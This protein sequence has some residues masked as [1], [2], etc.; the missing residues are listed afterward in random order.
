MADK[1]QWRPET[2]AVRGGYAGDQTTNAISVPIYQTVGF[3]FQGTGHAARLFNLEQ[4]GNIYTRIM[5]PTTDVLE[6]RVALLEGGIAA[7]AFSSGMAAI[8]GAILNLARAGDEIVAST[9]LYGGTWTLFTSTLQDFGISVRLLAEED[10]AQADAL[11]NERTKGVFVE[12]IGNP[13]LDIT[14][15][16]AWADLAH[17]HGVPLI[18]DNTFA[19]PYL[20]R[21][22][23]HG[24]DIVVHSLTKWIGG[25]GNALGG[26]VVDSGRFNYDSAR[27]P[28]YTKPDPSYHGLV[29]STL[30]EAAYITR[31]RVK[32]LRDTG[33]AISP[34]N[35]YYVLQGLETL[36]IRM[37][38]ESDT[39]L[40]LAKRLKEHPAVSWVSYPGL[41]DHSH[42]DAARRYLREGL[43]GT[44]LNFGVKGG[45]DAALQV[46]DRLALW[47]I[48]ANVGD[49]RSMAIHP[50]STTHQQLGAEEQEL[51]GASGDLI[52]LSVGLE[53][54]DDLYEDLAQALEG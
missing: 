19:T 34:T 35:A 45:Q 42:H 39:A 9:S 28:Y 26:I 6:Q 21:P 20:E 30:G 49:V 16:Q 48:V 8:T 43:Y 41:S 36:P 22:I 54:P 25:H 50:T 52:R 15:I 5:N 13:R 4:P 1:I 12:S 51:A 27:F 3:Q 53:H 40:Y 38:Q 37:R 23:D 7:L 11:F 2:L 24:A 14:D 18:V 32:I 17:R 29:F 47:L 44:M 33:A 31:L 10:F 46:M